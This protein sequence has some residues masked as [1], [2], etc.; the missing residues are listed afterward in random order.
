[1]DEI[2]N[3][4]T[5]SNRTRMDILYIGMDSIGYNNTRNRNKTNYIF[6]KCMYVRKLGR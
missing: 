1:M 3:I 2:K 4:T 5:L 6:I